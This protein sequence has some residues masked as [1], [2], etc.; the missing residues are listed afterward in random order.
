VLRGHNRWSRCGGLVA[1]DLRI[2]RHSASSSACAPCA[3]ARGVCAAI[4]GKTPSLKFVI[5]PITSRVDPF[6]E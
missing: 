1:G 2:R 4:A 6:L 5:F 3:V